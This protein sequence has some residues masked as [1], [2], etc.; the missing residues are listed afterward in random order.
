MGRV[1]R[2]CKDAPHPRPPLL[3]GGWIFAKQKDWGSYRRRRC[4]FTLQIGRRSHN[5]ALWYASYGRF[6]NHP[7]K[8]LSLRGVLSTT[9]QSASPDSPQRGR[10]LGR[11]N[12]SPTH[13][14]IETKH[15]C[16]LAAYRPIRRRVVRNCTKVFLEWE[17]L[18]K[19]IFYASFLFLPQAQEETYLAFTL[20]QL[21]F[22]PPS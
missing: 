14:M 12:P 21:H 15:A 19:K 22:Q 1:F 11:E 9:W 7:L 5:H 2:P 10:A 18:V 6:T 4:Q 3:R 13:F 17:S 20:P 16:V 8:N